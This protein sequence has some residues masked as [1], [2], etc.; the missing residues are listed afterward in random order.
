MVITTS[1]AQWDAR[2]EKTPTSHGCNACVVWG[3]RHKISM[4][5]DFAKVRNSIKQWELWP[6][7]RRSLV[8][9][10]GLIAVVWGS[11]TSLNQRYPRSWSVQPLGETAT[12]DKTIS[13]V[14]CAGLQ[15]QDIH[16]TRRVSTRFEPVWHQPLAFEYDHWLQCT[17][18]GRNTLNDGHHFMITGPDSMYCLLISICEHSNALVLIQHGPFLIC[19]PNHL[20][21]DAVLLLK[22][23]VCII[24]VLNIALVQ[25]LCPAC[26]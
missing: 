8:A 4:F 1:A 9:L 21:R 19:I 26:F 22:L 5:L 6:S 18:Y 10:V 23:L 25:G 12:L 2:G 11:N 14:F 3:G 17:S 20:I 7:R 13:A 16:C 24:E 15:R